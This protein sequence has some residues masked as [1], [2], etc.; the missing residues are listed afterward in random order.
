M[1]LLLQRVKHASVRVDNIIVNQINGGLLLFLG[2][3]ATDSSL[4]SDY[5]VD[6]CLNLRIFDDPISAKRNHLSILDIQGE[7]LVISQFTLY[8]NCQ[9]GRRPSFDQAAD[10]QKAKLLYEA[11]IQSLQ[12]SQLKV[13]GGIFQATMEID[14][15]NDGPVT[16]LLEK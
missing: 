10:P 12:K 9:N 2:I 7:I 4:Q 11:F 1:K 5:L 6:K 16:Y 3:G 8:G 13:L 14:L 15:C